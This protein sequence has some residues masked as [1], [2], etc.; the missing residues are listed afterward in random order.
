L[1]FREHCRHFG[2]YIRI[3]NTNGY[4]RLYKRSDLQ[5]EQ[6]CINHNKVKNCLSYLKELSNIVSIKFDEDE[7]S[8]LRKQYNN[9]TT[10]NSNSVLAT[11]FK[12]NRLTN[13]TKIRKRREIPQITSIR[14]STKNRKMLQIDPSRRDFQDRFSIE[15]DKSLQR[16]TPLKRK[17][18]ITDRLIDQIVYKLYGLKEKEIKIVERSN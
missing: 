6:N 16:L 8:Y 10:I 1:L 18:E 7:E 5:F 9:I 4:S 17:I 2:K 12:N 14:V 13:K 3:F 11:Y 15:F